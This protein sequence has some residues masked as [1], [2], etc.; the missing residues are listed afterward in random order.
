MSATGFMNSDFD[1]AMRLKLSLYFIF[2]TKERPL[3]FE[4][5]IIETF[6]AYIKRNEFDLV[7]L[8]FSNIDQDQRW[9][10]AK[11]IEDFIQKFLEQANK[12]DCNYKDSW[13]W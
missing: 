11:K 1:P 3:D 5:Y 2:I 12:A 9:L 8:L 10:L 13:K 7:D 4:V 6:E